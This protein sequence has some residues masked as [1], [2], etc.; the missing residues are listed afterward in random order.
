MWIPWLDSD[1]F[2]CAGSDW[3]DIW[4]VGKNI[5]GFDCETVGEKIKIQSSGFAMV[6]C[7]R[8]PQILN[9]KEYT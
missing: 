8:M 2:I 9:T 7:R 5:Y 4:I 6:G 1:Y 3:E